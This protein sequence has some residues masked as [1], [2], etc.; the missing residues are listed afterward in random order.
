MNILRLKISSLCFYLLITFSPSV[1]SQSQ[2]ENQTIEKKGYPVVIDGDTLFQ[3]YENLGP[4]KPEVRA[5]ETQSRLNILF[6]KNN[7]VVDSFNIYFQNHFYMLRYKS[8]VLLSITESDSKYLNRKSDE[9]AEEYLALLKDS[10]LEYSLKYSEE[11]ILTGLGISLGIFIFSLILLLVLKKIFPKI[12]VFI[13]SLESKLF[14]SITIKQIEI[15]TAENLIIFFLALAKLLR[16]FVTLLIIYITIE[17]ILGILPWTES[18]SLPALRGFFLTLFLTFFAITLFK[19]VNSLTLNMLDRF[20]VWKGSLIRGI[21]IKKVNIVSEE[22][23]IDS[24]FVLLRTFRNVINILIAYFYF[25]IVLSLYE[26]THNWAEKLVS[27]FIDPLISVLLSI[28]NY[29][30][31]LVFIIVIVIVTRYII[32]FIHFIFSEIEKGNLEFPRFLPDWSIPT[33]KIFRFLIIV[34]AVIIIYPHLPGSDSK[35]FEGVSVLLGI[36]LSLASASAISN[37][38]SG[39]VLTYMNAFRLGDRV[40]IADTVGDI[41]EKTLLATRVR[42]TKNVEITIPNSIILSNHII[43]FSKSQSDSKLIL[44]TTVTI[45]YDAPWRQVH[46][47]LIEAALN[48][49]GIIKEIKP[50]VLQTS[51]D[52]FYVSY[53][54]NAYTDQPNRMAFVFSELHKNIQDK[55]NEAG[56]EIMSPHYGAQRDGNQSTIPSDYLPKDYK[57][58]SFRISQIWNSYK[59]GN[60]DE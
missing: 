12:Y 6:K 32:K 59:D 15:L 2:N 7:V 21:S 23:I 10:F 57:V 46:Q 53:E 11:T 39:T 25:T 37:I 35:A 58:P 8:Q 29:L 51:L 54:L 56:V 20:K 48:S 5:A 27:Y 19:G 14:K 47:L 24:L 17:Q 31:S 41:I 16:L 26:F 52:D 3:F 38:V 30:P 43:N 50:F 49:E 28:I 33:F 40:K 1:S 42:T 13:E 4:F 9:L 60:K 34:F 18:W 55:F 45:G 22:R 36:I 44:N